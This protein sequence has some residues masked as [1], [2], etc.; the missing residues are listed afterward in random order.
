MRTVPEPEIDSRTLQ[1]HCRRS[2][3]AAHPA[4]PKS[5]DFTAPLSSVA[6]SLV[7]RILTVNDS[8]ISAGASLRALHW[9]PAPRRGPSPAKSQHLKRPRPC[10]L[11]DIWACALQLAAARPVSPAE[12]SVVGTPWALALLAVPALVLS[13]HVTSGCVPCPPRLSCTGLHIIRQSRALLRQQSLTERPIVAV[14]E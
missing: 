7:S 3:R 13:P 6:R 5:A 14:A 9:E 8:G 11:R 10:I 4:R 1:A 2:R 12:R